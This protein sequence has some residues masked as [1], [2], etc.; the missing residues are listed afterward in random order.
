MSSK[1]EIAR[2]DC[3]CLAV[4]YFFAVGLVDGLCLDTAYSFVFPD[5]I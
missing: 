2:I 5:V 1:E 3:D 4:Y